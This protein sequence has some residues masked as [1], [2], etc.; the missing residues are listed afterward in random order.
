MDFFI[1]KI[2]FYRKYFWHR[3]H[4]AD[5]LAVLAKQRQVIRQDF[6]DFIID[7]EP[8]SIEAFIRPDC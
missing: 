7:L 3:L 4:D 8:D 2:T 1:E 6:G 5:S